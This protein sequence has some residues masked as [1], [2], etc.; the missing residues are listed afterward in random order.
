M[1]GIIFPMEELRQKIEDIFESAGLSE[2]D[3]ALWR[4]R[5]SAADD[6]FPRTFVTLFDEEGDML[7]FFTNDLRKR[8]EAGN[9][10]E[11]LSSVLREEKEYFANILAE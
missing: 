5:L 1:C 9:D 3:R 10:A 6:S 2:E 4:S 11:K 8:A 7:R